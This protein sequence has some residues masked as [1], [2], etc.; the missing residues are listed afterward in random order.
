MAQQNSIG[1]YTFPQGRR[2]YGFFY[3]MYWDV[4][5]PDEVYEFEATEQTEFVVDTETR[6]TVNYLGQDSVKV[7]VRAECARYPQITHREQNLATRVTVGYTE[8]GSRDGLIYCPE[9]AY[10]FIG[11]PL[12]NELIAKGIRGIESAPVVKDPYAYSDWLADGEIVMIEGRCHATT[13]LVIEPEEFN[14]CARCGFSPL[15]CPECAANRFDLDDRL[16]CWKCGAPWLREADTHKKD[17]GTCR[18]QMTARLS[19]SAICLDRWDGSDL[20]AGNIVTR[21]VK[22]FLE[23]AGVGSFRAE[24]VPVLMDNVSSAQMD[25]LKRAQ[26]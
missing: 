7:P 17:L 10:T 14:V 25:L 22:E 12:L 11:V 15:V 13:P 6:L 19:E 3:R 23:N 20:C 26:G 2:E 5:R 1:H 21:R 18:V 9:E 4:E 16:V 8:D 24:A